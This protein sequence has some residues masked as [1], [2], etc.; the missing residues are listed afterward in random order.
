MGLTPASADTG[1]YCKARKRLP[2]TLLSRLAKRVGWR[3][4][5]KADADKLWLGRRVKVVDGSSAS[6]PDTSANQKAYPQPANQK[7]GC[8]FP[9][10]AF[11]AVFCL[12]TGA[13]LALAFGPWSAH[14]LRLFYFVRKAFVLGDIML[15]DRAFG[16]YAE[17]ALLRRKGVDTVV[18]LHQARGADFRRGRILGRMD[19]CVAW[20]RPPRRP[21]G[22][23]RDDYR[24]LPEE[25]TV[26]ELRYS[27]HVNGFRTKAV[28]LATTLLDAEKYSAEAL[29]ELYFARWDVELNFQHIKTTM[30][31]DILRGRT[32]AMVRKE[33]LAY[34][35][36]YNLVRSVMWDAAE[37]DAAP[38]RRL[39]FKGTIQ[40]FLSVREVFARLG[41][42][43]AALERL[44]Q[45]VATQKVPYR[46]WRFEPRYRKRRP[47][48]FPLLMQPRSQL[49]AS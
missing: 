2:Q 40:Y 42:P 3:L 23:R 11:V 34:M 41:P 6:M 49:K 1:A 12:G 48:K 24:L 18:R 4:S 15:G 26:R 8:G 14:D 25:L 7:P 22:L 33:V 35:L 46:P 19:H 17:L 47:K 32:P 30:Q 44:L 29:A 5:N 27:V 20:T 28:T 38:V 9:V 36:A 16:S 21:K 13:M 10:V 37:I 43:G 45:F 31:M 39:S